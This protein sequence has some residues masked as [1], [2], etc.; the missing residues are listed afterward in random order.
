MWNALVDKKL[1]LLVKCRHHV[2][3][4]DTSSWFLH[5]LYHLALLVKLNRTLEDKDSTFHVCIDLCVSKCCSVSYTQKL[6]NTK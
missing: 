4:S 2:R 3:T 1:Q 5:I 6:Q